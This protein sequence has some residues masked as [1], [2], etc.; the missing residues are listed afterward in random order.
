ML[1]LRTVKATLENT[2]TEIAARVK[3][4]ETTLYGNGRTSTNPLETSL[5]VR[6]GNVE[7]EIHDA[8]GS[9][10]SIN[11]RLNSIDTTVTD[12]KTAADNAFTALN[13]VTLPALGGRITTA[14]STADSAATAAG[15]AQSTADSAA[16]TANSAATWI[17]QNKDRISLL[18][19]QFDSNGN[20]TNTSGL[21]TGN[22]SF[23]RL[24][25]AALANDG[26][27]MKVADMGTYVKKDGNDYI[28]GAYMNADDI[29]FHFTKGVSFYAKNGDSETEVMTL[30]TSGNLT[31]IGAFSGKIN[32]N[33]TVGDN[34]DFRMR[35]EPSGGNGARL[36]GLDTDNRTIL[37][38]G[39]SEVAA[40]GHNSPVLFTS[41]HLALAR[42]EG[43]VTYQGM[44]TPSVVSLR[45]SSTGCVYIH[46]NTE[47][48]IFLSN[49]YNTAGFAI[50]LNSSGKIKI[51][52]D[53]SLWNVGSQ[54]GVGYLYVDHDGYVK[55]KLS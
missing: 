7:Q 33:V 25:S 14:Q 45:G 13:N 38:L 31:I 52:G 30:D 18:S 41:S 5:V 20:L 49:T 54:N 46:S 2:G 4:T 47:P 48:E 34:S 26:T 42:V 11:L 35:I 23:S 10:A 16:S 55:V 39:Y 53:V 19:A 9:Y 17:T 51:G 43:S 36:I 22:G 29:N 44:L 6:L 8:R 28:T 21:V 27:V 12:N 50:Q 3:G 15:N 32:G 40:S 24:F 37:E 1:I